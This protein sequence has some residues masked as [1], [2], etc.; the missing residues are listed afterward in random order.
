M[1]VGKSERSA[2]EI[3]S[4]SPLY[5]EWGGRQRCPRRGL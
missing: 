2:A 5:W 4:S 1:R 3:S